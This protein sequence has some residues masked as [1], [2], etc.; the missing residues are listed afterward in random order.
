MPTDAGLSRRRVCVALATGAGAL[1]GRRVLAA[2]RRVG[3]ISPG[4]PAEAAGLLAAIRADLARRGHA[5]PESLALDVRYAQGDL[6]LI[7]TFVADLER[8]QAA[9]II[10]HAVATTIVVKSP[11]TVPVVYHFS[12]DPVLSGIAADLAHPL[13]NATGVT[14]MWAELNDKRLELLQQILPGMRRLGV[15]ANTQHPGQELERAVIEEKARRLGIR[16][17]VYT[18][19]SE[20]ELDSAL[21]ALGAAPPE[22]LLALSDG[23]VVQHRHRILEFAL[24]R[25]LPVVSGWAVM[26]ESGA[27][28]TYGPRL[29]D[30]YARV[31]YFVDRILKGSAASSL[32]IEQP[33]ILEFVINLKT[34]RQLGLSI[35][36][37]VLARADRIIE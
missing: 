32:P 12:A 35:P 21:A 14:L 36:Q 4:D 2:P 1:S 6:A 28:G 24:A 34:A 15:L 20:S 33:T 10:T 8:A 30:A 5:E 16:T 3:F 13:F 37:A 7:P 29:A 11:R 9:V 17:S 25:R 31:G 27:L 22:A 23:F 18:V 19:R 26:A